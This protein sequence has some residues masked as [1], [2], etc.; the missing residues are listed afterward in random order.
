MTHPGIPALVVVDGPPAAGKTTIVRVLAEAL[1]LPAIEKDVLKEA[2]GGALGVT[3][4]G[5][6]RLLGGAVF[7]VMAVVVHQLILR[8]VSTIAEGN[9]TARSNLFLELPPCRICQVHVTAAPETLRKRLLARDTHRHPVHYD[10]EAA[11]EIL[12]RAVRGEWDP[13]P[14]DGD[15]I[16]VDTTEVFPDTDELASIVSRFVFG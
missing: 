12:E 7:E 6:S 3:E 9:F 14:L 15:L 1:G 5:E 4:R 8:G 11:D 13:L 16:A 10:R 2:A